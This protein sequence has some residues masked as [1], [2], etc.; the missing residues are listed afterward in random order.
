MCCKVVDS[1]A[2]NGLVITDRRVVEHAACKQIDKELMILH[3]LGLK[4]YMMQEMN[5]L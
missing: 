4:V 3:L 5:L 2:A 1:T